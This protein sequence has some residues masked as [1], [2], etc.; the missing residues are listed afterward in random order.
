MI[1]ILLAFYDELANMDGSAGQFSRPL[2]MGGNWELFGMTKYF[3]D[4][5]DSNLSPCSDIHSTYTG[6]YN[7]DFDS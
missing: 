6:L 3:F 2:G 7:I 1:T 5:F 4:F